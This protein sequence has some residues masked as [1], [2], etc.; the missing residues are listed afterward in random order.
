MT[1]HS[2]TRA[3]APAWRLS[4]AETAALFGWWRRLNGNPDGEG[5][6]QQHPSGQDRADSAALR[7]CADLTAVACSG[8]FGR[9]AQAVKA[10][11]NGI[12]L[13]PWQLD[14]L[15]LVA[16]VIAHVKT[17]GQ[18]S[19][20]QQMRQTAEHGD[21][22]CVSEQRFQRLLST[23]GD[24]ALYIGLRRVLPLVKD[25]ADVRQLAA[26]LYAWSDAT[27]KRWAYSYYDQDIPATP[28]TP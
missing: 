7:R 9:L 28:D 17:N 16:G 20:P 8:A 18:S 19:L 26:D 13:L 12:P 27:R 11:R 24:D 3:A 4:D 15:A 14:R 1:A 2:G 10:A 23:R 5:Q 25:Q 22:A 21:R 6:A